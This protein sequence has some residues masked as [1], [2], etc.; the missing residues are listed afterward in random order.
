MSG[1]DVEAQSLWKWF[2]LNHF[3]FESSQ[4]DLSP[5]AFDQK[6]VQAHMELGDLIRSLGLDHYFLHRNVKDNC[7]VFSLPAD[8]NEVS[9][10][11]TDPIIQSAPFIRGWRFVSGRSAQFPVTARFFYTPTLEDIDLSDSKLHYIGSRKT[12]L[13]DSVDR[14]WSDAERL[15]AFNFVIDCFIG[16]RKRQQYIQN[17]SFERIMH[18]DY[19]LFDD[20]PDIFL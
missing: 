17:L 11:Y 19:F 20:L 10:A 15:R 1:K 8:L 6:E 9:L 2:E 18:D 13:I 12:L 5:F 4:S 3:L 14:K 7:F 16:E